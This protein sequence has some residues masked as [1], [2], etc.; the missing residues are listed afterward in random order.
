VY[1]TERVF[2]RSN[3]VHTSFFPFF[4]IQIE[5]LRDEANVVVAMYE[6][7]D[8]YQVPT[9]PEDFAVYQTLTPSIN[10]VLSCIDKALAERDHNVEAFCSH[11]DKDIA[12]LMK[13]VKDVKQEA[14]VTSC[15][16]VT[17]SH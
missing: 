17:L 14:Q 15:H 7:I 2:N 4:F 12:E 6:L 8:R 10:N 9:P 1:I 5:P 11:L 16:S 13:E 3:V